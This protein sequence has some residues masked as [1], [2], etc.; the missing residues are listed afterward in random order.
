MIGDH[1]WEQQK[2]IW[3]LWKQMEFGAL[4]LLV[5]PMKCVAWF[6]QGLD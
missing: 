2:Q 4:G 1:I 3:E 5:Q 6:P